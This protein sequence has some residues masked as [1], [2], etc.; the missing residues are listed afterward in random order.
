MSPPLIND[1]SDNKRNLDQKHRSD[2]KPEFR[3]VGGDDV[4]DGLMDSCRNIAVLP[5]DGVVE[6]IKV[7][8]I[9]LVSY[10]IC[11]FDDEEFE[12][13]ALERFC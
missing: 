10:S 11:D 4:R 6:L 8:G 9:I 5:L 13:L 3:P 2:R 7:M 12:G 1:I